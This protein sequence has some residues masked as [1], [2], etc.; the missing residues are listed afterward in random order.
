VKP[1]CDIGANVKQGD[2]L[3]IIDTPELDKQLEQARADLAFAK[4]NLALSKT[5]AGALAGAGQDAFRFPTVHRSG[6]RQPQHDAG[7]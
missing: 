1:S 5:T 2:L 4:S 7:R 6:R 3:A